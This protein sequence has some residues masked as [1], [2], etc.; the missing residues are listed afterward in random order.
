MRTVDTYEVTITYWPLTAE[1]FPDRAKAPIG[2]RVAWIP[3]K[4]LLHPSDQYISHD[5]AYMA[6]RRRGM[7]RSMGGVAQG[8]ITIGE[9]TV[10]QHGG[11][12]P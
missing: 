8:W 4:E 2:S 3:T 6:L 12:M 9:R 7:V 10:T 1:G 5:S 11:P